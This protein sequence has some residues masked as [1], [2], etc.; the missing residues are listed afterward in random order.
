M[1]KEELKKFELRIKEDYENGKIRAPV[2][3]SGNNEEELIKIFKNIS[4][5]DWV[6]T[7]WR[8]HYHA[9]LHGI[10]SEELYNL[11]LDGRSMSINSMK[12]RFYSSSIVGGSIPIALGTALSIKLKGESNKVWCFVGDMSFESGVFHECYKYSRNFKLPLEFVIEDNNMSTNTP[13]NDAWGT[14]SKI[15]NDVYYYRY[16]REYPHHGTGNWIL[17]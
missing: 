4:K 2:H 15:P 8:N 1:T 14:K 10:D 6:F 3:L 9:L 7:T 5:D 13:T 17:F 11:I 12:H 16:E